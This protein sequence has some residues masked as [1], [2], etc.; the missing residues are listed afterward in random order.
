MR[1]LDWALREIGFHS[2]G[3]A[4]GGLAPR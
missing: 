3:R 4:R 2:L 1:T